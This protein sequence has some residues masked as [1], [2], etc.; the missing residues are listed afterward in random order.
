VRPIL[1]MSETVSGINASRLSQRLDLK[2][3]DTELGGLATL[4]N[5][6]LER[7]EGAFEQQTRFT[8]D[9]SHE[10][11][12]PLSVILT[13]VE[14]ALSRPREGA[15]YRETLEACGRAARR[16]KSLVDDLLLLARAD[17]GKLE[18]RVQPVDLGHIA[19]ACVALLEPLAKKRGVRVRLEISPLPIDGDPERLGQ[20]L[21][22][23]LSNAIQYNHEGG[24]VAVTVRGDDD[25]GSAIVIVEDTGVGISESDL[26]RVFDRFYRVDVARSRESGG[27]GLGLAIC[28]SIV[29]AHGGVITVE[30]VAGR[31]SRFTVAIPCWNQPTAPN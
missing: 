7:L 19:E 10:L 14:L 9:A 25:L 2:G 30:S 23:L 28:R 17:S 21:T 31:G 12:T 13:Q 11:R 24:E 26:P 8:A 16:M 29:E 5:A 27:S 6:M 1:A 22:N 4:I 15:S 3:I 20:V 18:L